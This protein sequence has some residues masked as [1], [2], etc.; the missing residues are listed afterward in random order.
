MH[1]IENSLIEIKKYLN[2]IKFTIEKQAD[3]C[4][5]GKNYVSKTRIDDLLCCLE[6]SFP[7]KYKNYIKNSRAKSYQSYKYYRGLCDTLR[8]KSKNPLFSNCYIIK[9]SEFLQMSELF[10]RAAK[11]DFTS[12]ENS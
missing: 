6:A 8:Q 2:K 3:F 5:F 12:I 7:D 4:F 10:I 1:N 9:I 11:S